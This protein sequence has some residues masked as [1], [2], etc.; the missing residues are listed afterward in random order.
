MKKLM[1]IKKM[2]E[3]FGKV[4]GLKMLG[5]GVTLLNIISSIVLG[6]IQKKAN[7]DFLK[8]EVVDAV[9]KYFEE[10]KGVH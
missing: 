3:L 5:Y 6:H 10:N 4:D 1:V 7:D 8:K 2:T 9:Q